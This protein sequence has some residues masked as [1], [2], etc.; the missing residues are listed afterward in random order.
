MSATASRRTAY[1]GETNDG[2]I[3]G[4]GRNGERTTVGTKVSSAKQTEREAR[5]KKK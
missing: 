5:A 2:T 3:D 4:A 1:I